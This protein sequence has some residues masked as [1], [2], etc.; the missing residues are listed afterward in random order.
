[1]KLCAECEPVRRAWQENL[2]RSDCQWPGP[3][4]GPLL[5]SRTA[6]TERRAEWDRRNA[7]MIATVEATCLEHHQGAGPTLTR[8]AECDWSR[9]WA[10]ALDAIRRCPRCSG[11]LVTVKPERHHA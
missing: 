8:C 7:E 3:A 11:R 5:D 6:P 1:M 10:G 2:P 9:P 4:A